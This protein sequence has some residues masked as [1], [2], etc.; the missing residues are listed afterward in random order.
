MAATMAR[1]KGDLAAFEIAEHERV[2]GI[3]E[4]G[5]DAFFMDVGESG[6]RVKPAASDNADLCLS[7]FCSR[8]WAVCRSMRLHIAN[9]SV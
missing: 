2:R 7:Q 4:W 3:A 8:G 1:E 6:H 5:F 9:T